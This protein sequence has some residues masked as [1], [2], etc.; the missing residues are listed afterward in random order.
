MDE[1]L[2]GHQSNEFDKYSSRGPVLLLSRTLIFEQLM[3]KSLE[4]YLA[5]LVPFR[6]DLRYDYSRYQSQPISYID[7][8]RLW[9]WNSSKRW[10]LPLSFVRQC[11]TSHRA[12]ILAHESLSAT[13]AS[14]ES[15]FLECPHIHHQF[16]LQPCFISVPISATSCADNPE[17]ASTL[18][19]TRILSEPFDCPTTIT[20]ITNCS[21]IT[22]PRW[23]MLW[24]SASDR[25][26]ALSSDLFQQLAR[27]RAG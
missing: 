4:Y 7:S 15:C 13:S 20:T 25:S 10:K 3:Q 9:H 11:S 23:P 17:L 5:Q 26:V 27:P 8:S 14:S 18:E 19:Q 2:E 12:N 21:K 22:R 1:N 24:S 16:D 6:S